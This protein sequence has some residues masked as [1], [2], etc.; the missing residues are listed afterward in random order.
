MRYLRYNVG[1]D[2]WI[3]LLVLLSVL[4]RTEGTLRRSSLFFS[5]DEADE[6]G[7]VL[8]T[9]L[10]KLGDGSNYDA[11]DR[12]VTLENSWVQ[13]ARPMM[14]SRNWEVEATIQFADNMDDGTFAVWCVKDMLQP[15][16]VDPATDAYEGQVVVLDLASSHKSPHFL[17]VY[18]SPTSPSSSLDTSGED[19]KISVHA[20]RKN[21][22]K[23]SKR[24]ESLFRSAKS[25]LRFGIKITGGMDTLEVDVEAEDSGWINCLSIRGNEMAND[26]LWGYH[27][28]SSSFHSAQSSDAR[29]DLSEL[30]VTSVE[31]DYK[32]IDESNEDPDISGLE[33]EE[34]QTLIYEMRDQHR[35]KIS[36]LHDHLEMQYETMD[37]HLESMLAEVRRHENSVERRLKLLESETFGK[38]S[39]FTDDHLSKRHRWLGPYALVV[40]LMSGIAYVGYARYNYLVKQH[41]L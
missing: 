21:P 23:I 14:I 10:W 35:R 5:Q 18:S 15:G 1:V 28:V 37:A 27:Y 30:V 26:P 22:Q 29:A 34:L 17:S 4:K 16:P 19:Q 41:L 38:V 9:E 24:C 6:S 25:G 33:V 40:V 39:A 12:S 11:E 20:N 36:E 31:H 3:L 32:S 8:N 7:N 2:T 13:I